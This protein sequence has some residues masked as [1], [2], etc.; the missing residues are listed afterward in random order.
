MR[1]IVSLPRYRI[2]TRPW[3]TVVWDAVTGERM[4][5]FNLRSDAKAAA[6]HLNSR[7]DITSGEVWPE[8]ST[9]ESA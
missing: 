4:R 9:G 6:D 2:I 1:G 7:N 5:V 8:F 3:G